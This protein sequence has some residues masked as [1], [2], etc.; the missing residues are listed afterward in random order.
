MKVAPTSTVPPF[1]VI[2]PVLE[3]TVRLPVVVS[4]APVPNVRL[5]VPEFPTRIGCLAVQVDPFP[6]KVTLPLLPLALP[7]KVLVALVLF[8]VPP[9]VMVSVPAPPAPTVSAPVFQV[10]P[11]PE[12]LTSPL[13]P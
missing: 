9:V 13:D 5:P 3:V 8:S 6:L 2:V 1:I 4:I 11:V 12:M 10:E 7:I